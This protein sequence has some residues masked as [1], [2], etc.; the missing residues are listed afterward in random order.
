MGTASLSNSHIKKTYMPIV[1]ISNSAHDKIQ[2]H[3][4][5]DATFKKVKWSLE[6]CQERT[7]QRE[8]VYS[9]YVHLNW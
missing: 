3:R 4:K 7:G 8:T 1:F 5:S 6:D 2:I 9:I